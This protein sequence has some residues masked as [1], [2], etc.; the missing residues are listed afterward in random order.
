MRFWREPLSA[1]CAAATGAGFVIEQ[2]L[3]PRPQASMREPFP[4]DF[5]RLE[6][7]P[8]FL[9]LVLAQAP[10]PPSLRGVMDA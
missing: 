6:R 7:E 1:L 4:A 9:I 10:A 2:L 5:E 3:E 8:G